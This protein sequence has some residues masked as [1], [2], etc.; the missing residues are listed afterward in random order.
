LKSRSS[1]E[2]PIKLQGVTVS[3]KVYDSLPTKPSIIK[4]ITL[5]TAGRNMSMKGHLLEPISVEIMGLQ[6]SE[7]VYVAPIEDAMLIGLDFMSKYQ[8][9]IDVKQRMFCVKEKRIPFIEKSDSDQNV[10]I[11]QVRI[12]RRTTIPAR[13]VIRIQCSTDHNLPPACYFI[14]PTIKTVLA[15]RVCIVG[16]DTPVMSFVNISDNKI[17]LFKNQRVGIV[18]EIDEIFPVGENDHGDTQRISQVKQ[19]KITGQL[20]EHLQEMYCNSCS[21]LN[22]TEQIEL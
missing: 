1:I 14:E 10:N 16:A 21:E 22:E 15:P 18:Y 3:D 4:H 7:S 9:E 17:T 13:S 12:T 19:T 2:I 5:H 8:A 6:F 11:T 20:P